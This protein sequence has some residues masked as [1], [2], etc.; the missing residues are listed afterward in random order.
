MC[1]SL[2]QAKNDDFRLTSTDKQNKFN[3]DKIISQKNASTWL[4]SVRKVSKNVF[5]YVNN[6]NPIKSGKKL[7]LQVDLFIIYQH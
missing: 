3:D 4:N 6:Y 1:F 5:K 7:L 2:T